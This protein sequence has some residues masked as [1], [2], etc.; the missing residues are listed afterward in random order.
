[1]L[2]LNIDRFRDVND[3]L[4]HA[5]GDEVLVMAAERL[6]TALRASD[7]FARLIGDEFVAL[8]R[9]SDDESGTEERGC[10]MADRMSKAVIRPGGGVWCGSSWLS[11]GGIC[12][13]WTSSISRVWGCGWGSP[14]R[15]PESGSAAPLNGFNK[16]SRKSR[17]N[18]SAAT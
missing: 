14:K 9:C 16:K 18:G 10:K 13:T 12:A 4:G 7:T 5:V 1:M 15:P 11:F 8:L 6:Q 3:A 17:K 2:L